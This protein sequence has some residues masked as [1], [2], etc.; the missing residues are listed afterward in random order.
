MARKKVEYYYVMVFTQEG[1][2]YV[3]DVNYV[4]KVAYWDKQNVPK[5]MT[6][7]Q[8]SELATCLRANLFSAV[9]VISPYQLESQPYYYERGTFNWVPYGD[10]SESEE[11][12]A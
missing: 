9:M 10:I 7:L 3:T 4:G 8:A 1:P 11:E 5:E 6:E 12:H 2:I